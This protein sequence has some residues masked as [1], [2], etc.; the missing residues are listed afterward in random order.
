MHRAS[1]YGVGQGVTVCGRAES[2]DPKG[3]GAAKCKA[4]RGP[5]DSRSRLQ[6]PEMSGPREKQ[7]RQ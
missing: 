5:E 6:R 3:S 2:G 1:E 4:S 7:V